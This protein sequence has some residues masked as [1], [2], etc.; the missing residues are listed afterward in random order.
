MYIACEFRVARIFILAMS[1]P[2]VCVRECL[3][4]VHV[5][6]RSIMPCKSK[7]EAVAAVLSTRKETEECCRAGTS[8]ALMSELSVKNGKVYKQWSIARSAGRMHSESMYDLVGY[9]LEAVSQNELDD[10]HLYGTCVSSVV[11]FEIY[12]SDLYN[13]HIQGAEVDT[14]A[15][16][17]ITLAKIG[18]K[19]QMPCDTR[20][21]MD[22][23]DRVLDDLSRC[24]SDFPVSVSNIDIDGGEIDIDDVEID[25]DGVEFDGS[26][27]EDMCAEF[28]V[29]IA[30]D[31]SNTID[32]RCDTSALRDNALRLRV[33]DAVSQVLRAQKEIITPRSDREHR[34]RSAKFDNQIA[35]YDRVINHQRALLSNYNH[36]AHTA[37]GLIDSLS[38]EVSGARQEIRDLK[39][40]VN[41]VICAL[42]D[43]MACPV[44]THH[45]ESAHVSSSQLP[46]HV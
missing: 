24:V 8:S 11:P 45:N 44:T 27:F 38:C 7:K 36:Q 20:C 37:T 26:E 25:I 42:S 46:R 18:E 4:T 16:T 5:E 33:D 41:G 34:D 10:R 30:R 43:Y 13:A 40:K 32:T 19:A 39:E 12:A 9:C 22:A 17:H 23:G 28:D 3:L 15:R 35:K 14:N 2:C 31:M 6:K 1:V 21:D 29:D